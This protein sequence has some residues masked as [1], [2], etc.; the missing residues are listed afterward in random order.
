MGHRLLRLCSV[1]HPQRDPSTRAASRPSSTGSRRRSGLSKRICRTPTRVPRT[2]PRSNRGNRSRAG[3]ARPSIRARA[4]RR[5]AGRR[6]VAPAPQRLG[7]VRSK[8]LGV[9]EAKVGRTADRVQDRAERGKTATGEDVPLDEI[10]GIQVLPVT[11]FGHHD[12]LQDHRAIRRS[13]W[14][15]WRKYW[16]RNRCPTASI[17]SIEASL[18]ILAAEV[19]IVLLAGA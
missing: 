15:H 16:S 18:S 5:A 19:A 3:P 1:R 14:P 4:P 11:A 10:D 8:V 9:H 13:N 17:I 6:R 12:G 2:P 7:V